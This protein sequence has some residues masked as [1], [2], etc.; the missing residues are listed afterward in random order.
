MTISIQNTLDKANVLLVMAKVNGISLI[1]DIDTG[2]T[3][4]VIF[5]F[6]YDHFKDNFEDGDKTI[7]LFGID[8][9]FTDNKVVKTQLCFEDLKL[10]TE[11]QVVE[12]NDAVTNFQNDYGVQLHGILGV[13]FLKDNN[14]VIDFANKT[15][16]IGE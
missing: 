7:K 1:F 10:D 16:K 14:C 12:A 9:K 6:V 13:Q 4:N 11:F 5:D 8:G 2:A 3:Y 15:I